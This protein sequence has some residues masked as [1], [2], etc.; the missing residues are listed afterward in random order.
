MFYEF[1]KQPRPAD[2]FLVH[3]LFPNRQIKNINYNLFI[4]SQYHF[5]H[6]HLY[7]D[8]HY[9]FFCSHLTAYEVNHEIKLDQ[10]HFYFLPLTWQIKMYYVFWSQIPKYFCRQPMK[11]LKTQP[12]G[13][14]LSLCPYFEILL[15]KRKL[16]A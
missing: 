11:C 4:K 3:L 5:Y 7:C 14:F 9:H 15:C 10:S 16:I 1:P 6:H 13:R 8:L 12:F 2:F